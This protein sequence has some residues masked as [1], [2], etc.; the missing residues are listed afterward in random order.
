MDKLNRYFYE[1]FE[2]LPR[3]GPGDRDATLRALACLPPLTS[4]HRVLDIGCGSGAQTLD[5]ARATDAHIVAV[6]NHG[7]FVDILAG[8][9]TEFGLGHRVVPQIGDMADLR[10]PDE[11]FDVI[12]S[13]GA[14][15]II[16]F[17]QALSAWR[18]LL[19]PQGHMVISELCWLRDDPPAEVREFFASEG[20]D[21]GDFSARRNAIAAGGYRLLGDF[22]L[23]SVGWWENYYVP[24]AERVARCKAEHPQDADAL[25]VTARIEHEIEIYRR[26]GDCFGY[27][28][29][30]MGRDS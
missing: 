1:I 16:G 7:P 22:A 18:R 17:G 19:R 14:A 27:G 21:V 23:P 29:F 11:A 28:F 2:T 15:F 9:V 6:D 4:R 25:T 5:L 24:L 10:F 30:V 3:Q 20:A 26:H 13:E 8:K 12:W